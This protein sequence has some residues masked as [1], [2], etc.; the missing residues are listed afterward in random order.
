MTVKPREKSIQEEENDPVENMLKRTGC[1]DLH[2]KVQVSYNIFTCLPYIF[3]TI[4]RSE[5]IAF[6]N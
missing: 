5:L 1:I 6:P 2:Y 4:F 3:S